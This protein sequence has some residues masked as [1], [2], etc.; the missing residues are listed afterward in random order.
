ML[1]KLVQSRIIHTTNDL[2]GTRLTAA[3]NVREQPA[4][5]VCSESFGSQTFRGNDK[6]LY[7]AI[8]AGKIDA[9][10][11]EGTHF[12]KTYGTDILGMIAL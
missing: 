12:V 6:P 11:F 8:N 4:G 9:D 1:R 3:A 5:R 7:E 2:H 10:C